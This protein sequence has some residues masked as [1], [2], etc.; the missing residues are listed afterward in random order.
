MSASKPTWKEILR[1]LLPSAPRALADIYANV[2]GA[3]H[4]DSL[5][6]NL[7]AKVR[8]TL[9]QLRDEG[10]AIQ[11]RVGWW[12]GPDRQA[13]C[14]CQAALPWTLAT[15]GSG[16]VLDYDC[17]CGLRY[18]WTGPLDNR[19]LKDAMRPVKDVAER[20]R[21]LLLFSKITESG[22]D[23]EPFELVAAE[24]DYEVFHVSSEAVAARMK[25]VIADAV[26]SMTGCTTHKLGD[27]AKAVARRIPAPF[28]QVSSSASVHGLRQVL[29]QIE[30]ALG[31]AV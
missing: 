18:R 21:K 24:F 28:G 15:T 2:A 17:P 14:R 4:L 12:S 29:G 1:L 20:K 10:G 6:A 3:L 27:H 25:G 22:I 30:R 5:T 8:Q 31:P 23:P 19:L 11:V 7:R 26:V 13:L 16:L 9:Q